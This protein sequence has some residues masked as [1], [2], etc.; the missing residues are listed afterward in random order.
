VSPQPVSGRGHVYSFTVNHHRWND[1]VD[2]PYVVAIV[3]LDDEPGLR[4]TTNIVGCAPDEV[5]I[6]MAV[7]VEFVAQ[8]QAWIPV[9]RPAET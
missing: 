7:V 2:E 8:E 4:L 6:G 9:F 1:E 5:A 3:E